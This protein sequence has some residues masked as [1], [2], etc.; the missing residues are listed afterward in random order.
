MKTI[1]YQ[2]QAH[3]RE[4]STEDFAKAGVE[5]HK[6]MTFERFLPTE[7]S[8]ELADAIVENPDLFPDFGEPEDVPEAVELAK[9]EKKTK[10]GA[11]ATGDSAAA[12]GAKTTSGSTATS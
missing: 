6:A 2:G 9:V 10:G 12:S 8:N 3:F 4:L 11:D 1:A 7:V 5:G